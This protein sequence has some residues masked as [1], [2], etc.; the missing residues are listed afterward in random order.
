MD[1]QHLLTD[2]IAEVAEFCRSRRGRV[3]QLAADLGVS[4]PHVSLWLTHKQTPNGEYTLRLQRW[5]HQQREAKTAQAA[6][7]AVGPAPSALAAS[8]SND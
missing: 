1:S 2:L 7:A 4:Q 5:L 3:S 8:N 6:E